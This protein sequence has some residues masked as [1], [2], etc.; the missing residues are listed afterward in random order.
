MIEGD[1]AGYHFY[2]ADGRVAAWL[3]DAGLAAVDEAEEWLE[4]YGYRHLLVRP[5]QS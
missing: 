1:T 5:R 2:P 3:A 4:G